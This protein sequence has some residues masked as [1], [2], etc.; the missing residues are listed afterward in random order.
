MN[1][2][3]NNINNYQNNSNINQYKRNYKE[4]FNYIKYKNNLNNDNDNNNE[5]NYINKR[6]PDTNNKYSYDPEQRSLNI[7]PN[8]VNIDSKPKSSNQY[9]INEMNKMKNINNFNI[10]KESYNYNYHIGPDP[11]NEAQMNYL[12]N[13]LEKTKS[14]IDQLNNNIEEDA[15][16]AFNIYK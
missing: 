5:Q 13:L 8:V 16:K 15:S 14:E 9:E 4:D 7:K 2:Y 3:N 12:K 11:N 1:L 10:K 6:I